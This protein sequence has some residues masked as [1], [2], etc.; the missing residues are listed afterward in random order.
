[1]AR[2]RSRK[3]RLPEGD[4]NASIESLSHDGRGVAHIDGKTVFIHGA[5]PGERVLFSYSHV[6]K[7]HDEF[8]P[9]L[10]TQTQVV[11][12]EMRNQAGIVGAAMAVV[13]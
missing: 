7:K 11:P 4:F 10:T 3:K 2:R 12:A 1:M 13:T 9:Y 8:F 6:S 5:L